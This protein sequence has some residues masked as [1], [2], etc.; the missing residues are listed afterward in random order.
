MDR[1]AQIAAWRPA[2]FGNLDDVTDMAPYI[3]RR[4]WSRRVSDQVDL[5]RQRQL[6]SLTSL[7]R[8]VG[9]LVE[10]L[11]GN[12]LVVFMS[13][14]GYMWGE[15]R[16][17]TKKVPYEES[18]GIPM[19]VSWPGHLSSGV[20]RRLALS[21]RERPS[22]PAGT[23]DDLVRPD[24][25]GLRLGRLRPSGARA[26]VVSAW[27]LPVRGCRTPTSTARPSGRRARARP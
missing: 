6:E 18:I 7:D 21:V 24:P 19:I 22:P 1:Y 8:Q 12:T 5:V 3:Q 14:N 9:R 26:R 4:N 20:D 17:K 23:R 25:A 2:T 13:D 15:H 11:P 10:A 16:W 27:R